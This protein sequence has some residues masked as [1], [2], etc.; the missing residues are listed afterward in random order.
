MDQPD[1]AAP[2]ARAARRSPV[3]DDI[4]YMLP[5]GAFLALTYVGSTWQS[6]FPASYALK[7]IVAAA[8]LVICWPAYT[9][10][11]WTHWQLGV[12]VGVV[13]VVQWVGM[14]KALLALWPNYPRMGGGEPF[15]PDMTFGDSWLWWAFIAVRW[16]GP[17]LVVPVMEELFWRDFVWRSVSAPND[18]KLAD[19]GEKDWKAIAVVAGLFATVHVQWLTAIVWAMLIAWLLVKTRS[20]GACIIAHGV[21]N[22]LLGAWVLWQK[23]WYFW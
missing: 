18:F 4:A 15:N 9:R 2:L 20:L 5:M 23:D 14:E 3:R 13:G 12:L 21:T 17:T 1:S 10:V 22:F 8:L 16:A 19:V 11:R 6:L 7:T